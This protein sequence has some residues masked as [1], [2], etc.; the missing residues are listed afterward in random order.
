[1][2]NKEC[3]YSHLVTDNMEIVEIYIAI[4]NLPFISS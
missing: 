3:K 4:L 1:M 2:R